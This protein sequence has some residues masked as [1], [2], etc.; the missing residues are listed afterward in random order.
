M[1]EFQLIPSSPTN[2]LP[3]LPKPF[4]R[5]REETTFSPDSISGDIVF[6]QTHWLIHQVSEVLGEWTDYQ[7]EDLLD[8][9]LETIIGLEAFSH[10]KGLLAKPDWNLHN[11]TFQLIFPKNP[12]LGN[13]QQHLM[14]INVYSIYL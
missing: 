3:N 10:L 11:E 7:L 2:R 1:N 13:S 9:P 6:D 8:Q 14:D 12:P 5:G 4:W